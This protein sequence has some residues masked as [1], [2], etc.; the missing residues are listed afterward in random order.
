VRG[1]KAGG[2]AGA[3]YWELLKSTESHEFLGVRIGVRANGWK[4]N[5]HEFSSLRAEIGCHPLRQSSFHSDPLR[6]NKVS[7][8]L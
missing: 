3:V 5:R 7:L 1:R 8:R 4:E 6:A 2:E